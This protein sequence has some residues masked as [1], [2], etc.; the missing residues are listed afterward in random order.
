MEE[1]SN[2]LEFLLWRKARVKRKNKNIKKGTIY[3]TKS[4]NV[5]KE[6]KHRYIS[7]V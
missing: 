4:R 6:L 5:S 1:N 2:S 3:L 7:S